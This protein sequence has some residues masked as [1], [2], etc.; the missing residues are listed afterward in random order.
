[1][2]LRQHYVR[3]RLGQSASQWA[4]TSRIGRFHDQ[5]EVFRPRDLRSTRPAATESWGNDV[6]EALTIWFGVGDDFPPAGAHQRMPRGCWRR[7]WVKRLPHPTTQQG[8]GEE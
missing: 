4:P 1:M 5:L 3:F 2:L 7:A 6:S 8:R